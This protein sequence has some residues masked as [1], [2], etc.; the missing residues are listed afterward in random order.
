MDSWIDIWACHRHTLHQMRLIVN[1]EFIEFVTLLVPTGDSPVAF[2][3]QFGPNFG[4]IKFETNLLCYT[5]E[6]SHCIQCIHYNV[7]NYILL[8]RIW[9]FDW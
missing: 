8:C 3:Y 5:A 1:N 7:Y 2:G 4:L 9:K 6:A